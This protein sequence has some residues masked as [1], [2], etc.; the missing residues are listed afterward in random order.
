MSCYELNMECMKQCRPNLY[1]KLLEVTVSFDKMLEDGMQ[2]G[3]AIN[4]EP[5]LFIQ[6]DEKQ[7]RLNSCY[8]PSHEAKIWIKQ[9]K[10]L[11]LNSV[12]AMFGFGTGSFVREIV[13]NR[14]RNDI[15][16]VY[17]PSLRLFDY[18][19]H[20]F[21]ITDIIKQENLIICIEGINDFEF[22]GLLQNSINITNYSSQI[23]CSHPGYEKIYTDIAIKYWTEVKDSFIQARTNINTEMVFGKR[24]I[25]NAL[26]NTRYLKKSNRLMELKEDL[27]LDIPAVIVAGGPSVKDNISELKRAKGRLYIFA[28]DRVLDYLLEEGVEPDFIVTVDPMKP[29]EFFTER[30]DIKIPILCEMASNKLI[31][32][33]HKGRKIFFSC[34]PYF[35]QMY[36]AADKNPPYIITGASVATSAFM[37]CIELGFKKIVLVGQDLAY[38]GE[39]THAGDITEQGSQRFDIMVEGVDGEKVRSRR[40]WYNFSLWYKDCIMLYPEIQVIDAKTKGAKIHGTINMSLKEVLDSYSESTIDIIKTMETKQS[41]FNEQDMD[42][43]KRFFED[44]YEELYFMKKK[45]KEAINICESQ[46]RLYNRSI[47]ETNETEKNFKKISKINKAIHENSAYQLIESFITASSA[48]EISEMYQFTDN[49]KAD[50]L[51]TY[52]KSIKIYQAIID[53]ADYTRPLL[54]EAISNLI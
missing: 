2:H 10:F 43:I 40:D 20:N 33:R 13:L 5:Y 14:G 19:L 48:Q 44:G 22:H 38:D 46:I 6:K 34:F 53:G 28:V 3:E 23:R 7:Y 16:F 36:K 52:E 42:V 30:E 41:T 8:N 11:N 17:E 27:Q 25:E 1:I 47:Q 35:Q 12:I 9:Y 32:E 51:K 26:Y 45:A 21:N 39:F 29:M 31:L 18:V 37:T 4:G 49:A 15:L 54:E 24:F 50:K